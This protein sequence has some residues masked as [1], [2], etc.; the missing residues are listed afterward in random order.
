MYSI[1]TEPIGA[2]S[3]CLVGLCYRRRDMLG[4]TANLIFSPSLSIVRSATELYS[5]AGALE[6]YED[7]TSTPVYS[8]GTT[9]WSTTS[10][11]PWLHQQQHLIVHTGGPITLVSGTTLYAPSLLIILVVVSY[12]SSHR[13]Q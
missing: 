7:V 12:C 9:A 2:T 4:S 13:V 3:V 5:E 8:T 6:V 10:E 11:L 1:R